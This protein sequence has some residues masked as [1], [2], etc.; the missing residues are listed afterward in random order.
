ME[1]PF[2]IKSTLHY[3]TNENDQIIFGNAKIRNSGCSEIIFTLIY[4]VAFL[5][6]SLYIL[7]NAGGEAA[8]RQYFLAEYLNTA[9]L[10]EQE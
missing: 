1:L 5:A 6:K 8:P 7:K 3:D 2:C 9:D 10:A 4:P